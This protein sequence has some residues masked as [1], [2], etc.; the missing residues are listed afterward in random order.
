[1]SGKIWWIRV[2]SG[3]S[4]R[5]ARQGGG[6]RRFW[7]EYDA[8]ESGGPEALGPSSP[9]EYRGLLSWTNFCKHGQRKSHVNGGR[10][11]T[12]DW[13]AVHTRFMSGT[14]S[15][16]RFWLLT[17][18]PTPYCLCKRFLWKACT[19]KPGHTRGGSDRGFDGVAG[20]ARAGQNADRIV[21]LEDKRSSYHSRHRIEVYWTT[22]ETHEQPKPNV[23][24]SRHAT[25][26][27]EAV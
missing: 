21:R 2:T 15:A 1:M 13:A 27:W 9:P 22:L 10:N 3:S 16:L 20:R 5:S 6:A 12:C 11:K 4:R 7:T 24:R 25:T 23:N 18:V 26:G 19:G 8:D 17:S 14:A